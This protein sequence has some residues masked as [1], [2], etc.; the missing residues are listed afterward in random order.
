VRY[1]G[2]RLIHQRR[3]R[4]GVYESP[5]HRF[6]GD[7]RYPKVNEVTGTVTDIL[8]DPGRT[9]PI[10]NIKLNNGKKIIAIANEGLRVE[11]QVAMSSGAPIVPGN[12]L[13]LSSIPEGTRIYN[14]EIKPGDGGKL[15]RAGGTSATIIGHGEKTTIQLPSGQLKS[16]QSNCKATVGMVAGSGRT[17]APIYKAGKHWH[18]TRSSAK[19]WPT[20]RG[21]AM[22]PVDHPHGGGAHQHIGKPSTVSIHAPPGRKVGRL[23]PK[24]LKDGKR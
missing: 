20:V 14:I 4:G 18:M 24:K 12:V 13:P 21:V 15:V 9:A 8:H 11:Q 7:I 19:V 22:N 5:S 23:S 2:K 6:R 16:L 1:L 17:D 10:A 3:G